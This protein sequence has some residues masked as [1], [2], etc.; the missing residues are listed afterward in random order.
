M[1]CHFKV[2]VVGIAA[3]MGLGLLYIQYKKANHQ[4]SSRQYQTVSQI[5]ERDEGEPS[6]AG[7]EFSSEILSSTS[8]CRKA[9]GHLGQEDEGKSLR[10]CEKCSSII[11]NTP[12]SLGILNYHAFNISRKYS[13]WYLV[14]ALI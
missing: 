3:A 2:A 9:V 6:A 12:S 11:Q 5:G 13:V 14:R 7:K 10:L 8:H 4:N 1:F